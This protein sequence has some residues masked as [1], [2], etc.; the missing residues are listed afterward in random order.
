MSKIIICLAALILTGC[1]SS[2]AMTN[3]SNGDHGPYPPDY[4][5]LV[6][7]FVMK[8]FKDPYSVRDA[9]ISEPIYVRNVF[10]GESFIPHSGWMVCLIANSKNGFGA[11]TGRK[12]TAFI[13]KKG[14]NLHVLTDNN[15][16]YVSK[17]CGSAS[18]EAFP[19][20]SS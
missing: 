13:F 16:R 19:E 14:Y 11:Y 6:S 2:S 7:E 15:N 18:Y 9:H 3:A 10:D 8:S 12:Y 17:H 5:A 1:A 20:I 4:R